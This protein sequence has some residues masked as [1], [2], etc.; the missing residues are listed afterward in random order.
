M[1]AQIPFVNGETDELDLS[2]G[3]DMSQDYKISRIDYG[4]GFSQRAEK[5]LNGK[6]QRWRLMWNNI[7]KAD[8]EML[9]LFFE[10]QGG[11]A[12]IEWTPF[13]QTAELVWTANGWSAKPV[14]FMRFD[15]SITMTQEF[16]LL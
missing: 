3:T 14:G 13:G 4:D 11:V 2:Y 12:P 16:D 6:P 15:C 8:A 7:S 9:R 10:D 5:G 1:A